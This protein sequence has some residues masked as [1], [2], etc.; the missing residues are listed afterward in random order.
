MQS[1]RSEKLYR[2]VEFT[3]TTAKREVVA[4]ALSREQADRLRIKHLTALTPQQRQ[5]G[6]V[7]LV[8]SVSN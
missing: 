4:T 7:Y 8:E 2:V 5:A 6:V 1:H 3:T